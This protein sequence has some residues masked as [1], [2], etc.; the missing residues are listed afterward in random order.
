MPWAILEGFGLGALLFI[1]CLIGIHGGAVNMV[2]LYHK[3]VQEK[4]IEL[5]L[6]TRK[7]I[8]IRAVLFKVFGIITY[9]AYSIIFVYLV[10]G[11]RG[12][13]EGFLELLIILSIC[14]L[15]DRIFI[16]EL[17]VGHTKMWVIPGTEHLMPY[18][19]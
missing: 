8:T 4:A 18:K 5:G 16:D 12:F 14:N 10:N 6:I 19:G 1:Y 17:W 13:L 7:K 11:A 3:D 9:I 15:I 2:F